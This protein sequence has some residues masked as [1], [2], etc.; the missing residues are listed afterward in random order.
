M[1]KIYFINSPLTF[2]YKFTFIYKSKIQLISIRKYHT[3]NIPLILITECKYYK[4]DR[5]NFFTRKINAI[6][7]TTYFKKV[8]ISCFSNKMTILSV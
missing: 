6:L 3:C 2:C 7:L 1:F 4:K 8:I 5:H